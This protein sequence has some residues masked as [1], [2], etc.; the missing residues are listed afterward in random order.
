MNFR[1]T[2]SQL[3]WSLRN[4]L[5]FTWELGKTPDMEILNHFFYYNII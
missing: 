4:Q 1:G 3:D 5:G 2:F